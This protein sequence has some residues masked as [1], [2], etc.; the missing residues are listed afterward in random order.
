[1]IVQSCFE[2]KKQQSPQE[3]CVPATP[4]F[5]GQIEAPALG[6]P[7]FLVLFPC[8]SFDFPSD[9]STAPKLWLHSAWLN[10]Y[11]PETPAVIRDPLLDSMHH[12]TDIWK[13]PA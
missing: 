12:R 4:R 5:D 7:S 2:T 8:V 1:M 10:D 3:T 6:F 9:R 11:V 13:L